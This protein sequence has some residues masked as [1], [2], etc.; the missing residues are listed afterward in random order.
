MHYTRV[1]FC[2]IG[3]GLTPSSEGE[4]GG[5]TA[6]H[7]APEAQACCDRGAKG[8]ITTGFSQQSKRNIQIR[9]E[10]QPECHN[11]FFAIVA[12]LSINAAKHVL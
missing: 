7:D 5:G 11:K 12:V 8:Y 4:G 1:R 6:P 2:A 9:T 3:V 10:I